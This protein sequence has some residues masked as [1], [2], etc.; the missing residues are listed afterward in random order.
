MM[1]LTGVVLQINVDGC[2]IRLS[3]GTLD[4]E[5]FVGE[6]IHWRAIMAQAPVSEQR[7]AAVGTF[8][9]SDLPHLGSFGAFADALSVGD[10][11]AAFTH[12][13]AMQLDAAPAGLV[14]GRNVFGHING[15]SSVSSKPTITRE[16]T[17]CILNE[18]VFYTDSMTILNRKN[19]LFLQ[20]YQNVASV[21][22]LADYD[23][24]FQVDPQTNMLAV[25]D[26]D[27]P[28]VEG[29][30]IPISA[31]GSHNYGHFLFDG[32]G[33]AAMLSFLLPR[34]SV[35]L[36]SKG[37][38]S[39]QRQIIEALNLSDSYAQVSGPLRCRRMVANT[40]L[41]MHVAH[42]TGFIRPIF[43]MLRFRFGLPGGHGKRVM[44]SRR[45]AGKRRLVNREAIEAV[46][47][48]RGYEV[49][50]P[51]TLSVA[52]QAQ[53]F[54]GA[55]S[56]VGEVGAAMANIGFCN[57]GASILEIQAPPLI[58]SWIKSTSMI[59][60]LR[61][62]V[63]HAEPVVREDQRFPA[64]PGIAFASYIDPEEFAAALDVIG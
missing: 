36:V 10:Q 55:R 5:I 14:I 7:L 63:L 62:H 24:W 4:R 41:S 34:G 32:L 44:I 64:E 58:D 16:V 17:S 51:E 12:A 52:E 28:V 48:S 33:A 11:D 35:T 37:L 60:G 27:H 25:R 31:V 26:R 53:A 20:G 47:I 29:V 3:R 42:P 49:I 56:V 21:R 50:C 54:A 23:P 9:A 61:W 1:R 15:G 38:S 22:R 6:S 39:W 2:I 46:A 45:L 59:M 18:S 13:P 19:Q 8:M 30:L 40:T 57:P 43:D